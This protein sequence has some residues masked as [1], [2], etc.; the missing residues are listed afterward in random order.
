MKKISYDFHLHSCLSPCGS[1]D[2]TPANIAGMAAVIGLEAIALTDHNTCRNCPAVM[3]AAAGYGITVIPGME[4]CTSEE[5]H[6]LCFF[7]GLEQALDFD[8]FVYDKLPP[9]NND[10]YLFGNQILYN[11]RD[12]PCGTLEKLLISAAFLSFSELPQI[13]KPYEGIMIPAHIDKNSNSLISNLG[14][15]PPDSTFR[16][17]EFH[18]LSRCAQFQEDY[19]YLKKCRF[20]TSS[21]A[22]YLNDINEP[23]NFIETEENTLASV[24]ETLKNP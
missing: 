23:V 17:A 2:M 7:P 8:R 11:D 14:F 10:S 12:E 1:D 4:L 15:I 13:L 16:T 6:V 3:K 24:F 18:D 22:H 19:P 21:D 5:V 20:L 9:V